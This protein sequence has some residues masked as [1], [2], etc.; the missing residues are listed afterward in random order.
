[1]GRKVGGVV[2]ILAALAL[3]AGPAQMLIEVWRSHAAGLGPRAV[4][5]V[6]YLVTAGAFCLIA[7]LYFLTGR[8]KK[9]V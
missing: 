7:G 4:N 2:L 1:M 6:S 5:G 8:K 9:K 3:F